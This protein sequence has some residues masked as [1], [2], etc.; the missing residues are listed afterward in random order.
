MVSQT[1]KNKSSVSLNVV[2]NQTAVHTSEDVQN[3]K[4]LLFNQTKF[5]KPCCDGVNLCSECFFSNVNGEYDKVAN[6][7]KR[8][9]AD[10]DYEVKNLQ[11]ENDYINRLLENNN[12]DIRMLLKTIRALKDDV[13]KLE[14]EAKT[15]F[16]IRVDGVLK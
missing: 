4:D 10:L 8:N 5:K 7:K 14:A 2:S 1:T 13:S 11:E 15:E 12:T 9:F 16:F 3:N 6:Q